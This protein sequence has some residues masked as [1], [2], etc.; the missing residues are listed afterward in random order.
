MQWPTLPEPAASEENSP[1][2]PAAPPFMR[3]D[4]HP[5]SL[6]FSLD[7]LQS[8]MDSRRPF[9][10]EVDYT[11]TMMG[12]LLF[13][14][15]TGNI[16]MIGLGGGSL[17]KFC[18]RHLPDSRITVAEINP[19]VIALRRDFMIPEDDSRFAVV[20]MDG[21]DF[22]ATHAGAVDALLVDGFGAEG[23]P[24]A[25]C[26]QAFYDSCAQALSPDGILVV[27]LHYDS[28]DYAVCV[29][30]L[31]RSFSGAVL[32][33]PAPE[34]S[35]CIIFAGHRAFPPRRSIDIRKLLSGMAADGRQQ[36][37]QEFSRVL[38][39]MNSADDAD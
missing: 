24:P 8:R 11:R 29:A 26:S 19:H 10:L 37:Q 16:A 36:L 33:I 27:N 32:E 6:Y 15:A 34:K 4:G 35:N 13:R 12:F 17:A 14:P 2:G 28:P 25:L 31:Q 7:E 30:R 38:W 22:M 18:Y 1:P 5:R 39:C 23:Q 20:Q 3:V 9:D 21:A